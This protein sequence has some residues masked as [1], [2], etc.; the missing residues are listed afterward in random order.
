MIGGVFCVVIL[1]LTGVACMLLTRCPET[2]LKSEKNPP[3]SDEL[4]YPGEDLD[5]ANPYRHP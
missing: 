2:A 3:S 1:V 5:R 4:R